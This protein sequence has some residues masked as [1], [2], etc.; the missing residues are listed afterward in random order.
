M[1]AGQYRAFPYENRHL[2]PF[3]AAVRALNAVVAVKIRSAAIHA[4]LATVYVTLLP[5]SKWRS[6]H[7]SFLSSKLDEDA[8]YIDKDTRIQILDTM[9]WLPHADKEQCGAFIVS[10]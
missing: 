10:L 2:E 8:I 7:S 5:H 9:S 3:V 6:K 4:A 1:D